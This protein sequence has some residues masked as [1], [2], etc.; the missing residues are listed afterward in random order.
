MRNG[1]SRLTAGVT[2]LIVKLRQ[3]TKA[4][5]PLRCGFFG[6]PRG[7]GLATATTSAATLRL[8]ILNAG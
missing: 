6:P 5:K 3:K 1:V 8:T 4:G 2:S 7:R